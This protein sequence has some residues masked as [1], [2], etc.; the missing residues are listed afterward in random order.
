MNTV[1]VAPHPDDELI[2][3][4]EVLDKDENIIIIYHASAEPTRRDETMRLKEYFPNVK[5]QIFQN[6]VPMTMIN[7]DHRFYFPDPIYE[8]HPLHREL[9][10]AGELFGRSG[11]DVTFYNT[12]MNAPYIHEVHK[13]DLKGLTLDE[14]YP[15]QSDLWRF[16]QKYILFEGYCKWIF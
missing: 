8:T 4:F 10:M 14:V 3:C 15:S 13:K 6:S 5:A 11:F 2:G 7:Q 16:E 1:I 9:G 12:I